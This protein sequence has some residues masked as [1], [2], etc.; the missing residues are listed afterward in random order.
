MNVSFVCI[1]VCMCVCVVMRLFIIKD[2]TL[3]IK[4]KFQH[5]TLIKNI[6][7]VDIK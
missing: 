5:M 7:M 6:I 3:F 4:L 2:R 1:S